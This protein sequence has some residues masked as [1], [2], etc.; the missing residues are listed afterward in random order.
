MNTDATDVVFDS[1][2]VCGNIAEDGSPTCGCN[3]RFDM[4][5]YSN[6]IL[7]ARAE[8]DKA[9]T[10][11]VTER[12]AEADAASIRA[13]ELWDGLFEDSLALRIRIAIETAHFDQASEL[14][15]SIEKG[16]LH[17]SLEKRIKEAILRDNAA[18]EH[19]NIALRSARRSEFKYA[20]EELLKAIELA[21]HLSSPYRLLVKIYLEI[22]D[23]D[24]ARSWFKIAR[25]K[26][27]DESSITALEEAVYS[28]SQPKPHNPREFF[29]RLDNSATVRLLTSVILFALVVASWIFAI[30]SG[31]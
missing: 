16:D 6:I 21:P 5:D 1:C 8:L 14:L 3:K 28:D 9:R 20:I 10:L 23:M 22:P 29:T 12:Y 18:K 13:H 2:P 19:F 30:A 15:A 7:A 17:K 11:Y 24:N 25:K 4:N 27:K 26:F 31:K